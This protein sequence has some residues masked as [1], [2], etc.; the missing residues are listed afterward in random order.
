[1][2]R[3]R[4]CC[5]SLC[6]HRYNMI[7]FCKKNLWFGFN[8]LR[9]Q[10]LCQ[11]L[12]SVLDIYRALDKREYLMILFLI[13]H[14]NDMSWPLI[15]NVS[16]RRFR[17]GVGGHNIWFYAELTKII[18]NTPSYSQLWC[19]YEQ[20]KGR[21]VCIHMKFSQSFFSLCMLQNLKR[22]CLNSS[23]W[24]DC[25]LIFLHAV[26]RSILVQCANP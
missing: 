24:I 23:L 5:I 13:S 11:E 1:M 14:R 3:L 4:S 19:T 15:W 20:R 25:R 8:K 18:P 17:W 21:L 7:W 6:L 9:H 12:Q 26:P 2:V 22:V 10:I 16:S